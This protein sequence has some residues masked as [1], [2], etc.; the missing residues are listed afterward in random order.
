MATF[1]MPISTDQT[2]QAFLDYLRYEKRFSS[3]T[4]KAY[5][6]DLAQF[7]DFTDTRF[8][9]R[10]I[11]SLAAIHIRSWMADMAEKAMKPRSIN[12]KL[13]C[14]KSFY[15][16]CRR[17]GR[18]SHNPATGIRVLKTPRRLPSFVE[19]S[20]LQHLLQNDSF[21]ERGFEGHTERLVL[22]MLYHTGM[23]VSELV[24]LREGHIDFALQSVKVLGKGNKE[25]IIPLGEPLLADLK[26]Y[27]TE[28]AK[29]EWV[30]TG[31]KA[32]LLPESGEKPLS[33]RKIYDIV[34]RNLAQVTTQGKKS[35]HVLRH[36]FATHLARNG[37]DLNAIKE[38]LGHASL[39]ATQVYTHHSMD[40]LR[41]IHRK[42]HPRG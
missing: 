9:T 22:S 5:A 3:H 20:P 26:D 36:S 30:N 29:Q 14:L 39:A 21:T 35:P 16:F 2:V 4:V 13:S 25:R 33:A 10:V 24:N 37:A 27:F 34:R 8:D 11:L 28:K 1:F 38:L 23:R 17:T 41:D 15:R 18:L 32:H 42:A 19:E 12:R 7:L 6:D 31:D 40:K